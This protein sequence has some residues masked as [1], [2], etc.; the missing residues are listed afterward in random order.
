VRLLQSGWLEEPDQGTGQKVSRLEER[1]WRQCGRAKKIPK[2][3]TA[4][5]GWVKK[6][7]FLLSG[8]SLFL[9]AAFLYGSLEGNL[10][11]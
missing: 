2:Q 5:E 11:Y 1:I 4:E 8:Q 6:D 10:S 3:V 7:G 9:D